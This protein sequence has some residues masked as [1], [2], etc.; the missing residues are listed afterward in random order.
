M[1]MRFTYQ[2]KKAVAVIRFFAESRVPELTKGKANKLIFLSDKLHLVR[3]GRPITG[4]WY[5]ALPHGPVPSATDDMLDAFE[6]NQLSGSDVLASEVYLE[7]RF[8]Y[9]RLVSN[10]E[11]K[12]PAEQ[13]S[14]SDLSVLQEVL[15]H[16]GAKTFTELRALTHEM[17]AYEKAWVNRSGNR[18]E[19]QFEDFF[20][21]DEN[22]IAGVMAEAIENCKLRA[23]F[24][25]PVWE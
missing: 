17:P 15:E 20:E 14:S 6:A 22:A 1:P 9:P 18:A 13:L 2:P 16:F 8:Q 11:S 7:R 23:A 4:D 12:T 24:P 5:A 10:G 21:E 19:M 3:F 25:E